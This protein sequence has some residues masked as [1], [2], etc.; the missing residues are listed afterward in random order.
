MEDGCALLQNS[1]KF[2]SHD[3]TSHHWHSEYLQM[4]SW[5]HSSSD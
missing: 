4:P 5:E 3:M 2:T 1:V